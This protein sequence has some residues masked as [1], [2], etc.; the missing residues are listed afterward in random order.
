MVH[1]MEVIPCIVD[2]R[3][4]LQPSIEGDLPCG[5]GL[6]TATVVGDSLLLYGGSSDFDPETNQCQTFHGD[7]YSMKTGSLL[8][9]AGR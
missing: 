9:P 3:Q 8:S 5:R 7:A 1:V 2:T 6:H 4:W